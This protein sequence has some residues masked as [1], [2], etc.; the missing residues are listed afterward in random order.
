MRN[1]ARWFMPAGGTSE[2]SI[3]YRGAGA[4]GLAGVTPC[5]H[6]VGAN[7][8]GRPCPVRNGAGRALESELRDHNAAVRPLFGE[9]PTALRA[10]ATRHHIEAHE[11]YVDLRDGDLLRW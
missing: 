2:P 7:Q 6:N 9:V 8:C 10:A 5:P 4:L 1:R 11:A 3:G